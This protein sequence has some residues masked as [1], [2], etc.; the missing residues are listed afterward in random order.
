[1]EKTG[2]E[3]IGALDFNH[4][5]LALPPG[6]VGDLLDRRQEILQDGPRTEVDLGVD[7]HAGDEPQSNRAQS[8]LS[9][10][11]AGVPVKPKTYA[12]SN[13]ISLRLASGTRFLTFR[14]STPTT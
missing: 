9:S 14:I 11:A 8:D 13:F 10:T 4:M 3:G 12:T 6:L 7:L 2:L 1:M 5:N